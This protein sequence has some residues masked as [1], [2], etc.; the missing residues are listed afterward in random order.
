MSKLGCSACITAGKDYRLVQQLATGLAHQGLEKTAEG[1]L[2]LLL[3]LRVCHSVW[4]V[5]KFTRTRLTEKFGFSLQNPPAG[6]HPRS[7]N[8]KIN[9]F[10]IEIKI[11]T[12]RLNT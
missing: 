3:L 9:H 2:L 7:R 6:L 5:G 8:D 1:L 11:Y 4:L 10:L 12:Y